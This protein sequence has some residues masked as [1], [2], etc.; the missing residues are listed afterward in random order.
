MQSAGSVAAVAGLFTHVFFQLSLRPSENRH[1]GDIAKSRDMVAPPGGLRRIEGDCE[2]HLFS[3]TD[4]KNQ[5][6]SLTQ[7]TAFPL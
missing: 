2:I 1:E 3:P 6:D 5:L 4:F 7:A